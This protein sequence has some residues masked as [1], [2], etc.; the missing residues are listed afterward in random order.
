VKAVATES[1]PMP[2]HLSTVQRANYG[3]NQ[4]QVV[5]GA[6]FLCRF[7]NQLAF[8]HEQASV[9]SSSSPIAISCKGLETS[10][11]AR[12]IDYGRTFTRGSGGRSRNLRDSP[13]ESKKY[14]TTINCQKF[15]KKGLSLGNHNHGMLFNFR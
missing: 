9:V 15:R 4:F 1:L 2:P 13:A 12:K 5:S 8:Y 11:Y 6:G 7:A 10:G 3:K 14:Q